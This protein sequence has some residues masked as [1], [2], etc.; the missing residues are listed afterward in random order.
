MTYNVLMGNIKPYSLTHSLQGIQ[1]WRMRWLLFLLN[2]LQTVSVQALLSDTCSVCAEPSAS[3]WIC[4]SVWQQL[5]SI[6]NEFRR[7][8][9]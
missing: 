5:L 8:I 2:H 1:I 7:Y 4:R 6:F 9:L 3:C